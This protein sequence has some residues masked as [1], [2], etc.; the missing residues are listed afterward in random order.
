MELRSHRLSFRNTRGVFFM[1]VAQ[2]LCSSTGLLAFAPTSTL[3]NALLQN[4]GSRMAG[5]SSE[6]DSSKP[7][8]ADFS[9]IS[10][11]ST[12][13]QSV[14]AGKTAVV[15]GSTGYI[16]RACVRECVARG[17]NTIALVRDICRASTDEALDGASLVVCDVTNELEVQKVL[18]EIALGS[19]CIVLIILPRHP[20]E[21]MDREK[22]KTSS[23]PL[24]SS[25]PVWHLLLV[26]KKTSTL[27]TI[28]RH[29]VC[30][31]L[32]AIHQ[33]QHAILYY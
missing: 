8:F 12:N 19:Y 31:M 1:V 21:R 30:S 4:T 22:F 7:Y 2:A 20:K 32:V 16:G 17:Y 6:I 11:R 14:G 33:W 29:S 15:A 5:T 10:S 18:S 26:L 25:Y 3:Q 28:K 23:Y 9:T 27:S 13:N 24:I